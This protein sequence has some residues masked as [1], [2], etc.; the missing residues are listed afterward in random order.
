MA[1]RFDYVK[2]DEQ[3]AKDQ[4]AFKNVF[5]ALDDQIEARITCPRSKA[6]AYTKAEEAY[7]WIGKGIRNDQINRNGSAELTEDRK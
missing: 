1:N 6:L 5:E 3:A 4:A 2:Y 7:M